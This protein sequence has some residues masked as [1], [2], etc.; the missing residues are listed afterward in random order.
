[1]KKRIIEELAREL[2]ELEEKKLYRKMVTIESPQDRWV[3]I[4]G[5]WVLLL[6]SNNYLGL[7]SHPRVIEKA[8]EA[9]KIYGFGNPASRLVSGNTKLHEELEE[10]LARFK[11]TESVLLFSTGYMA[12]IGII[13]AICNSPEDLVISDKLNHASIIDGLMLSKAQFATF[14]HNDLEHL[15]KILKGKKGRRKLI[16]VDGVF[17]MDGDIA[18]LRDIAN[19]AEE[20]EALL[21]VDDAHATGVIGER[22]RG[23]VEY[24]NL[25][26]KIDIQMGTLGKALG[27]FGAFAA[28]DRTLKEYFINK[29]RPFIF[30]TSLPIPVVAG[31]ME[32]LN[33]LEENPEL[34]KKLRRNVENFV[35]GLKKLGFDVKD[36]GT[37]IVP[38]IAGEEERALKMSKLLFEEGVFITAIRPP[39][40]PKGTSRLRVT[41]TASH[42][43]EDIEFALRAFEKVARA[44]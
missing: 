15:E 7:A 30:T 25:Y 21:M 42:T 34:I 3:K 37:A 33:I 16:V 41:L 13:S 26:G 39:T 9:M 19:L 24:W 5:R 27:G 32:A 31:V 14:R 2:L 23:S 35:K 44:I 20:Y 43:D 17:S 6:C 36:Q 38:I 4:E 29:V 22:G 12:N 28:V 40:V 8:I 10:K 11:E 18:P 1:M